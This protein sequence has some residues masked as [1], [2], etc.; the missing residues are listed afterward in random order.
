M[1]NRLYVTDPVAT[2]AAQEHLVEEHTTPDAQRPAIFADGTQPAPKL[3]AE[4]SQPE[5][6]A[7]RVPPELATRASTLG[8][9]WCQEYVRELK[10]QSRD[11]VGGWPGTLREARRR[12]LAQ[13]PRNLDPQHLEELA[14]IAN[15]A[16]RRDWESISEP[17]LEP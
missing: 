4:G 13:M 7:Y 1:T 9:I 8:Q 17:D 10:G 15:L 3:P 6:P 11:I 2:P 12:V 5:A 14:R 16:A